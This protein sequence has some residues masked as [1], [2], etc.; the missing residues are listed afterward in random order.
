[1]GKEQELVQ[2][3]KA[4]DVGTAQR[5]LQ[6]PRPGKASECGGRAGRGRGPHRPG[7]GRGRDAVGLPGWGGAR[8]AQTLSPRPPFS[9]QLWRRGGNERRTVCPAPCGHLRHP[10]SLRPLAIT[11]S[12][13]SP[14]FPGCR[15]I[16]TCAFKGEADP[17]PPPRRHCREREGPLQ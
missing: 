12:L 15:L 10:L 8:S 5:L 3:V 7:A 2:A 4:E 14:P 13:G 9:P 16:S 11:S 6:R 17:P 1:M